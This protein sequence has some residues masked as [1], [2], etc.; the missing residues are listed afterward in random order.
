MML[1]ENKIGYITSDKYSR[2]NV[3]YFGAAVTAASVPKHHAAETKMKKII[4]SFIVLEKTRD[5]KKIDISFLLM[6][7]S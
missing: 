2:K 6:G 5:S 7:G 1:K 3:S 4:I